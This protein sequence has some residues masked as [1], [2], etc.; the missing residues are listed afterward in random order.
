M[1][2]QRVGDLIV[3]GDRSREIFDACV[4][5]RLQIRIHRKYLGMVRNC[6]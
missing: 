1:I 3:S 5:R 2:N 4:S 6:T